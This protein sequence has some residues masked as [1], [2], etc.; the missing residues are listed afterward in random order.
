MSRK[1]LPLLLTVIF[2][3][4]GAASA[5]A[6]EIQ[7]GPV[8]H[9]VFS[10]YYESNT[11]SD[12]GFDLSA[13]GM[14]REPSERDFILY[15]GL[16]M[17]KVKGVDCYWEELLTA[18]TEDPGSLMETE[19]SLFPD[20]TYLIRCQDD[21][22]AKIRV[23]RERPEGVEFDYVL[24]KGAQTPGTTTPG[25]PTPGASTPGAVT[26]GTTTPG[27]VTPGVPGPV[28]IINNTTNINNQNTNTTTNNAN[29][30]TNITGS[31]IANSNIA[32]NN[33]TSQTTSNENAVTVT[34]YVNVMVNGQPLQSDVKPFVNADGRTMLPVRSIA[35]ALGAQVQWNDATQTATLALGNKTVN[36]PIGQKSMVVD[37]QMAPLDTAAVVK[38]GRT[39]LP[40]R[41]VGEVLGAKIGWDEKSSTVKI[42]TGSAPAVTPDWWVSKPGH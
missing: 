10:P 41:A 17:T 40:V 1:V 20:T 8:Q 26:P 34:Q 29:T 21:T 7:W 23:T 2:L 31:T 24:E 30:N 27:G 4:A 14:T 19:Y 22:Y 18:P 35:E 11:N 42:D 28:T 37:G 36:I 39:L 6:A 38:D 5:R 16:L 12:E 32:S 3:F 33:K 13:G 25:T 9:G 15:Q